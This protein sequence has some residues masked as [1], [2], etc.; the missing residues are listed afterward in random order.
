MTYYVYMYP[1]AVGVGVASRFLRSELRPPGL[2]RRKKHQRS[3]LTCGS[4][5]LLPNVGVGGQLLSQVQTTW[6]PGV[7]TGSS[8][9]GPGK[10]VKESR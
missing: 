1:I 4:P 5:A 2:P 7:D 9:T 6:L 8:C 3:F 10:E